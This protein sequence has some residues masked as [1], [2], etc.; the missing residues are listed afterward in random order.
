[1]SDL[2]KCIWI[3]ALSALVLLSGSCHPVSQ[4]RTVTNVRFFKIGQI[5]V[6]EGTI[7]GKSAYFIIDT[8]A[9]CSILNESRA[10]EYGFTF[11]SVHTNDHLTGLSGDVKI[12]RALDCD[13]EI[14]PLKIKNVIFHSR[15]IDFLIKVVQENGNINLAGIIGSDILNRYNITID[16]KKNLISF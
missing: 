16:F 14:G 12:N 1:M 15:S 6:I 10:T 11:N 2:K 7:N 8:G 5:P 3:Q 4:I 9:S 13:I